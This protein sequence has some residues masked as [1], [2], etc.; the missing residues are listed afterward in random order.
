MTVLQV[1]YVNGISTLK[2][3]THVAAVADQIA[4]HVAGH[5]NRHYSKELGGTPVP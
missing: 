5:I 1:S 4:S 2:G 3:G